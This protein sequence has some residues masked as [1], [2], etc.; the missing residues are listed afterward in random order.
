MNSFPT[1]D[2]YLSDIHTHRID[3]GWYEYRRR[4][5]AGSHMRD[6]ARQRIKIISLGDSSVGKSC[7]IKRYCERK[8]INRYICTIGID[9]GVRSIWINKNTYDVIHKDDSLTSTS[10]STI[11]NEDS[12]MREVLINFFDIAGSAEYLDIRNEFHVDTQGILLVFDVNNRPSYEHLHV[13]LEEHQ[14][15]N[16][17]TYEK[18]IKNI[19]VLGNK[20]DELSVKREVTENEARQWCESRNYKYYETSASSGANVIDAFE[21]FFKM[22]LQ[23][24]PR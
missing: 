1:F 12:A 13:W 2:D 23:S 4:S 15:Y 8:F 19:I 22:V 24:N 17:T 14:K 6:R 21:S 10:T 20:S 7:L 9:F 16:T 3:A 11:V 18:A 5:S